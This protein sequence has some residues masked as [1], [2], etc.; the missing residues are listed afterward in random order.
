MLRPVY[1][2]WAAETSQ[3]GFSDWYHDFDGLGAASCPTWRRSETTVPEPAPS[4][5]A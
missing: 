3:L 2:R 5:A 1:K 4:V